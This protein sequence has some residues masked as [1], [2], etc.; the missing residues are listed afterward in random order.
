L[1]LTACSPHGTHVSPPVQAAPVATV[2]SGVPT[3]TRVAKVDV[4]GDG[5]PD[6]VGVASSKPEDGGSITVRVRTA[7]GL[8]TQTTGRKVRWF[9]KSFFGAAPLDGEDGA[10]LFVGDT[11][12]AHYEQFRVITFRNGKLVTL[13]APPLVW[14]KTGAHAFTPRWGVDGSWA[15]NTGVTRRESAKQGVTVTMKSLERRE[16]GRGH[17]GHATTYRWQQGQWVHVSSRTL[18]TTDKAAYAAGGWHVQ[19]LR[20]FV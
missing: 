14:S 12:G 9:G 13:N 1:A 2:C 8:T 19:G 5:R 10:E 15:F 7:N 11:M 17:T 6:Q 20:R 18:R 16:S 3:C 4:D